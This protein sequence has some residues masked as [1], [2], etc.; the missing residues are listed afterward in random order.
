V[1]FKRTQAGLVQQRAFNEAAKTVDFGQVE[2]DY[3]RRIG[4]VG[5]AGD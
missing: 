1:C 2:K 3:W 4:E 5:V